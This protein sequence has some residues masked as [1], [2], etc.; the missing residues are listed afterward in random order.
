M[1]IAVLGLGSIGS[2]VAGML[3]SLDSNEIFIHGRGE[4]IAEIA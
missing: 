3:S 1:K 2:L 4:H